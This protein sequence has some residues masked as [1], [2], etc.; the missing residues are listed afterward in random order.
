M[1][2]PSRSRRQRASREEGYS[3]VEMSI[4]TAAL[5]VMLMLVVQFALLW[6]GRHVAR[7]AAG[8]A[9]QA[10]QGYQAPASA[11]TRAATSYL[12]DVAPTLLSDPRVSVTQT[13][14]TVRIEV[15]ARVL[16]IIPVGQDDDITE[17][18]A[19]PRERFVP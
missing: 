15:R 7:A 2:R 18:V 1:S 11:G 16:R 12:R 14:T 13:V 8:E 19:G 9:L 4:T 10:A 6:H 3:V 5:I 17:S